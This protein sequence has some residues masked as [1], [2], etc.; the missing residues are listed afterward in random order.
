MNTVK[1]L[2]I[3]SQKGD[4]KAF[5]QLYSMY[6]SELYKF[7]YYYLGNRED[8]Q[9]AVQD[10]VISAFQSIPKL[11]NEDAF[12]S[13]LFKILSNCCNRHISEVIRHRELIEISEDITGAHCDKMSDAFSLWQEIRSLDSEERSIVLLCIIAGYK[14]REVSQI[15]SIPAGTVRSKLSRALAKLRNN[16]DKEEYV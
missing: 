5:A 15:L 9:D 4:K 14:S 7:A 11:K 6:Q 3:D 12:K 13:W 16:L 1:K 2:V 8:A 10:A